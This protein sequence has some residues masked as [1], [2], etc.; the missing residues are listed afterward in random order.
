MSHHIAYCAFDCISL[1]IANEK[2]QLFD[3]LYELIKILELP[4]SFISMITPAKCILLRSL[5]M[6]FNYLDENN[7]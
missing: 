6:A 7:Q 5:K 3:S 1:K 4:Y 2:H